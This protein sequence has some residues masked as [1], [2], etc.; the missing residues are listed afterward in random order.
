[1]YS[2]QNDGRHDHEAMRSSKENGHAKESAGRTYRQG[3]D[4][5]CGRKE[6]IDIIS[7][8]QDKGILLSLSGDTYMAPS[9][10]LAL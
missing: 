8:Y 5:I 2:Y 3:S 10:L 9:R 6:M 4:R 7:I 1:M